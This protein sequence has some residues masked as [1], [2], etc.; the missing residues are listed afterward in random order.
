[1]KKRFGRVTCILLL[2]VSLMVGCG[3]SAPASR[4]TDMTQSAQAEMG[5]SNG[6]MDDGAVAKARSPESAAPM[7]GEPIVLPQN[8]GS[9]PGSAK[10]IY[11]G[12]IEMET[13]DF[14]EATRKLAALVTEM[15]GYFESRSVNEYDGYR[16]G[17]Y[18][19]RVSQDQFEPFCVRAGEMCH[20]LSHSTSTEDVS[21]YY[22]DTAGRL[23]TQQTKLERL[24][25]LLAKAEKMEDII[26]LEDAI[27]ETEQ[28]I[29]ELSGTLRHYD[30]L[31][32]YSTVNLNLQEVY[33]LQNVEEKPGGFGD[34]FSTALSSGWRDFTQGIESLL[35]GMAY[36]WTGL[37][38]LLVVVIIVVKV[39]RSKKI[40]LFA[41]KKT[42]QIP[43][44]SKDESD[45]P[46]ANQKKEN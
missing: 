45:E 17:T 14:S 23:K 43:P 44:E 28:H 41:H 33:Q 6:G 46:S 9:L 30:S 39:V 35:V 11:T 2:A 40:H 37:L 7:P 21:E 42:D 15:K 25:K 29:D 12:D 31:V 20:V 32:D 34:R 10:L 13:T 16:Y 1:M 38:V 24:Q 5:M 36:N 22:Y 4:N 18:T 3:S 27:S 8:G 19:I 26:S